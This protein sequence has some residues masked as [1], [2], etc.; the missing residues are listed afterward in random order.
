[1]ELKIEKYYLQPIKFNF[2]ELKT[3]LTESLEKYQGLVVTEKNLNDSTKTRTELNNLKKS[4]EDER[5]R[6]KKEWN[7]PYVA[8]ENQIKEL[9]GLVDK[10]IQCL[11]TQIKSFENTR[12][13]NKQEEIQKFFDENNTNELI[14][15]DMIFDE[16]WLNK[17]EKIEKIKE[18]ILSTLGRIETSLNVIK[19][20]NTKYTTNMIDVYLK[21]LDLASALKEKERLEELEKNANLERVKKQQVESKQ[22]AVY[23]LPKTEETECEL[24]FKVVCTANQMRSLREFMIN[25]KIKFS[26]VEG[27]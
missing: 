25:N 7:E 18:T 10:P 23:T 9:V 20:Q 6:I 4:I 8:F 15:L 12:K 19:T 1:M 2:N 17:G 27:E 26:K 16:K 24:V 5:K 13:E 3:K 22:V 14:K 11:D 21:T